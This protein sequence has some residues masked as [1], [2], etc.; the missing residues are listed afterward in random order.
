MAEIDALARPLRATVDLEALKYNTRL[1][2]ARIG[3][4]VKF[5]AVCKNDA[6]GVGAE[7]AAAVIAEAGAD[8]FAVATVED[9]RA[10]LR[11]NTGLPIL[12]YAAVPP[13]LLE[14]AA[15]LGLIVTICDAY[16]LEACAAAPYAVDAYLKVDC[17]F[18][19]LGVLPHELQGV[20]ERVAAEPKIRLVGVYSHIVFPDDKEAV[21]RQASVFKK[22][23]DTT[24]RVGFSDVEFMA[25]GSRVAIDHPEYRFNAINPGRFLF[26]L[27]EGQWGRSM[28]CKPV[29]EKLATVVLQVKDLPPGY[30]A[31]RKSDGTDPGPIRIAVIAAGFRDGLPELE[32]SFTVLIKGRRAQA[33][34]AP[35]TEYYNIDIT[36][37][38]G[39][40]PGDEVVLIGSQGDGR[41]DFTDFA[42]AAGLSALSLVPQIVSRAPKVFREENGQRLS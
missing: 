20:L 5:Y 14:E 22:V 8:A 19:R 2:R 24:C 21:H 12:L 42:E 7:R 41:I 36:N 26:G 10:I 3:P 11:A 31:R 32:S 37:I 15:A 4:D 35:S 17:G 39:V 6:C 30:G 27:V 33:S 40:K 16:S 1:I 38:D 9:A 25:S 18:G 23:M 28:D 34:A 13:A 29:V